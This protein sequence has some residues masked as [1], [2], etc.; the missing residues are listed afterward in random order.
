[1]E[2]RHVLQLLPILEVI[3][4]LLGNGRYIKVSTRTIQDTPSPLSHH[5][6]IHSPV[7]TAQSTT[8]T[9]PATNPVSLIA[10][11]IP[12]IPAPIIAL[13]K[14][15]AA[16]PTP[17]L[18]SVAWVS[19]FLTR[20]EVPPGVETVTSFRGVEGAKKGDEVCFSWCRLFL[21]GAMVRGAFVLNTGGKELVLVQLQPQKST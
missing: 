6:S 15:H 16:P 2:R 10:N 3:S 17:L 19:S 14:L 8:N 1:M 7:N 11:G 4:L 18:F 5:A 21:E 20:R 12:T 13:T 9:T